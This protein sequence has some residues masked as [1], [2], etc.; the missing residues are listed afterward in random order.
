MT[1]PPRYVRFGHLPTGRGRRGRS[2][3][4][5]ADERLEG[6][7][8]YPGL[9]IEEDLFRITTSAGLNEQGVAA[10]IAMG[11]TDRPAFFL[12][13]EEVGTGPDG[14]PLLKVE[15]ARPVPKTTNVTSI[16]TRAQPALRL[17]SAGPRDGSGEKLLR[18]RLS[19]PEA[20]YMPP[21]VGVPLPGGHRA[22]P[23]RP[24]EARRRR[25][26]EEEEAPQGGQGAA[27][28]AMSDARALVAAVRARSTTPPYGIHGV[29]HWKRVAAAGLKLLEETPGADGTLVFLF[30][31][32]HDSVRK[33]DGFDP[34]HG[35]RAAALAHA[36]HLDAYVG[37]G[38]TDLLEVALAEH[39]NGGT[40]ED[41]TVGAC[42]DADRLN[43]W[44]VGRR[45]D[46]ALLSTPAARKPGRIAWARRL[47]E[48]TFRW[49]DLARAYGLPWGPACNTLDGARR[50]RGRA[51]RGRGVYNL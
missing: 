2:R 22:R 46:P 37:G 24:Q 6:V 1:D 17:W 4:L 5:L 18:W 14:E 38:R 31:L 48:G 23:E 15:S 40:S 20:G 39:D 50:P 35:A 47:Q 43:L 3:N 25:P 30:A 41:P 16:D 26:R 7:S 36:L 11:A 9:L 34:E 51:R 21:G 44:R 49:E 19:R 13:G 32:F 29:G 28:E 10:L 8:A 45:P 42:W 12:E 27:E 33:S